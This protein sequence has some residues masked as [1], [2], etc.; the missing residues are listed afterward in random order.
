MYPVYS[1][2]VSQSTMVRR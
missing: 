2:A 1:I